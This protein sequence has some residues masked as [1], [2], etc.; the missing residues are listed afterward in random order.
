MDNPRLFLLVAFA[1][2]SLMLWQ[3]WQRDYG[4]Q[5]APPAVQAQSR[6]ESKADVAVP[7]PDVGTA[8]A[9][10]PA[11][12]GMAAVRDETP[13]SARISV[14]TDVLH[15][16]IDLAGGTIAHVSLPAFPL[17]LDEP[18]EGLVLLDDSEALYFVL[19]GG[20]LGSEDAPSHRDTF[21]ADAE[22]YE[23]A[24]GSEQIE[25]RLHRRSANLDVAKVFTFRRGSYL[26]D[27]RYEVR[28]EG[29]AAVQLRRYDQLQRAVPPN[30]RGLVRTFTGA[31]LS[32]PDSRYEKLSFD[33]LA[34]EPVDY[35]KVD[36]WLAFIQ[37]YFVA[38]LVPPAGL[39]GHYYSKALPN[40]RYLV[41]VYG[42]AQTIAPGASASFAAAAYLGPKDQDTL[43]TIAPGLDLTVDYGV[44]WFIAKPL[45]HTL[46][47]IHRVTGNWGWSIILLTVLVKAL[48]FYPSAIGYRSMAKMRRVTPRLQ[49]IRE[50]YADDRARLQQAMME[51]YKEEKINPLSGCLPILIQVPVF[52]SLYWVLLESVELRQAPFILWLHDLS[53]P[54]PFFALPLFMGVT[55]WAQQKLNPAPLDP[56]QQRVMQFLPVVFTVMFAWFPSGL[57]LYWTVSNILSIAQQYVITRRIEQGSEA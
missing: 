36:G 47:F 29:S 27:M 42:P 17:T 33:D 21:E 37:H 9:E 14:R 19:Q 43:E 6:G 50:R 31:A 3:A 46:T 44:L 38:A 49:A 15:V 56:V 22:R 26:V 41:G 40:D 39:E 1:F 5:R 57:V 24:P 7:I 2:V 10:T 13:M 30:K 8:P 20:L 45:F 18:G 23:L 16:G 25:V 11:P 55:M 53:T 35:S 52:I 4:P 34:K 28:N 32:P 48:F 12:P 51:I 54:D